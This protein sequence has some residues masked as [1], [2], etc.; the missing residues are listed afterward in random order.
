MD[1]AEKLQLEIDVE[2]VVRT[3]LE[4]TPEGYNFRHHTVNPHTLKEILIKIVK[5]LPSE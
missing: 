2:T 5:A 1:S 3:D 4:V